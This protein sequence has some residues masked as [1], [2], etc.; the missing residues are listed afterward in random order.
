MEHLKFPD[1]LLIST[2]S[3]LQKSM[4][5]KQNRKLNYRTV[6]P[7]CCG[8]FVDFDKTLAIIIM[9]IIQTSYL[10]STQEFG[11]FNHFDWSLSIVQLQ[12]NQSILKIAQLFQYLHP[13][14]EVIPCNH[15]GEAK[16]I[17]PLGFFQFFFKIKEFKK[18]N[19]LVISVLIKLF[20]F[21]GVLE[22][23]IRGVPSMRFM[24]H[25]DSWLHGWPKLL[26]Y[27]ALIVTIL[28]SLE[29]CCNAKKK[30]PNLFNTV[31]YNI[32]TIFLFALFSFNLKRFSQN[33]SFLLSSLL[34]LD[35]KK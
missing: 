20:C 33:T 1:H 4:K 6:N 16:S 2:V 9:A 17:K 10:V 24:Q 12:T 32:F 34:A 27:Q 25:F 5:G 7:A 8:W 21:Q 26:K 19:Q 31:V 15:S 3:S 14:H 22:V 30:I 29:V 23:A 35:A 13:L 18:R 28:Y 11:I